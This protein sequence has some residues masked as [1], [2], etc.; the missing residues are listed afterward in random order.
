MQYAVDALKECIEDTEA[1][2]SRWSDKAIVAVVMAAAST[3]AFI[4]ELAVLI[5]HEQSETPPIQDVLISL[6][7][8]LLELEASRGSINLKYLLATQILTGRS[9]DTGVNPYQ[10]FEI[11]IKLRNEIMHVKSPS[12]IMKGVHAKEQNIIK[13]LESKRLT[14]PRSRG[15]DDHWI[16][17]V[18]SVSVA[19]WACSAAISMIFSI[20]DQIPMGRIKTMTYHIN[21][22]NREELNA[23]G[24]DL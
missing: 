10:D 19:R 22:I 21:D 8:C 17:R 9:V 7:Q 12:V 14:L 3:E 2:V 13:I 6:S 1:G 24:F 4:N 16:I 15:S 23:L 5:R 18:S 11:L 20:V